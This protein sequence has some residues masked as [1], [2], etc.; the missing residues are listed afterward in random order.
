MPQVAQTEPDS[1]V[2]SQQ[3]EIAPLISSFRQKVLV[4]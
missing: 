1:T 2:I 4:Q 3:E